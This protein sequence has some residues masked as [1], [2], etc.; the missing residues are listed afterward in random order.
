MPAILCHLENVKIA[1]SDN[2]HL[3]V[4]DLKVGRG[5]IAVLIGPNGCGKSTL[6]RLL[7]RIEG[8]ERTTSTTMQL[9]IPA[10]VMVWQTLNLFPLTVQRNVSLV[11][12]SGFDAIL[13]YFNLWVRRDQFADDLSGGERQKLAIARSLAV[14][15]EMIVID[16]PTSS[17]DGRSVED[18]VVLL[19]VYSGNEMEDDDE[20]LKS[21][22]SGDAGGGRRSVLVVTHDLRFVRLISRYASVRV[23]SITEDPNREYGEPRFVLH[24]GSQGEGYT[25]AQVHSSPPNLFTADFFGLSNVVGFTSAAGEP[26]GPEDFCSR[27]I[28]ESVGCFVMLDKAILVDP[29]PFSGSAPPHYWKGTLVG[30]EYIGSQKRARLSVHGQHGPYEISVPEGCLPADAREVA[31]RFDLNNRAAWSIVQP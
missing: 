20:Y 24:A 13:K 9:P 10:P 18:L 30:K 25:I 11:K 31:V 2:F 6:A 5:T 28:Q 15:A 19:G 1:I 7:C 27:Y 3:S 26:R 8:G 22:S 21:L 4:P 12:K 17:L 16:E 14:D 23:F 29:I